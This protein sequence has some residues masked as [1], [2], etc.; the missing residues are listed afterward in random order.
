M[1]QNLPHISQYGY[2]QFVTFRTHDSVDAYLHKILDSPIENEKKQY[3]VDRYL[4]G[5]PKGAY[6]TGKILN[7]TKRYILAQDNKLFELVSFSLMPNHIHLLFK[8]TTPL[9]EAMRRL[10]GGLAFVINRELHRTGKLWANNY[11]DKMIRDKRHFEVVYR[12]I[13]NN[14]LKANLKDAQERFYTCYQ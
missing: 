14:A 12:Y 6:L 3:M 1:N 13:K 7:N 10:K 8:E 2:Y 11:Y 5:S 9:A 4:D